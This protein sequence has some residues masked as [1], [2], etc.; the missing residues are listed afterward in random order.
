MLD[1]ALTDEIVSRIRAVGNPLKIVLYGSRARGDFR[2]DS[3]IDVLV[4][5]DSSLPAYERTIPYYSALSQLPVEVD[6]EVMVYT[7][8]EVEEWS[9][10]SAAFVTTALREGEILFEANNR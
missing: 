10:A 2:P 1:A 7:P 6:C 4:I 9:E 5:E 3:D 8:D